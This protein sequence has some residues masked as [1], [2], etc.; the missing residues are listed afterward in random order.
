MSFHQIH[1]YKE[2]FFFA[3]VVPITQEMNQIPDRTLVLSFEVG[4]SR[5]DRRQESIYGNAEGQVRLA[6][7]ILNRV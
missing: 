6:E 2:R 7:E 5:P 1:K 3:L 4:H